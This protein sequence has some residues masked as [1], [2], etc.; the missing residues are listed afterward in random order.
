[1]TD[2]VE[3]EV[4][5]DVFRSP[6]RTTRVV[7]MEARDA[8]RIVP[9]IAVTDTGTGAR[10]TIGKSMLRPLLAGLLSANRKLSGDEPVAEHDG[11][12]VVFD[13]RAKAAIYETEHRDARTLY[14][15]GPVGGW[16]GLVRELRDTPPTSA[17][18]AVFDIALDEAKPSLAK[19]RD[20]IAAALFDAGASRV[21]C[22]GRELA[23]PLP[24]A[25]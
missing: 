16:G 7:L 9:Y 3:V 13:S 6:G 4:L 10:V 5:A 25:G 8:D 12:I 2:H 1:M 11:S 18:G 23:R 15:R 24:K 19:M 21:A 20:A 14:P 17:Y 22:R